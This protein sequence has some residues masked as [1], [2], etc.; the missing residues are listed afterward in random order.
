MNKLHTFLHRR[1]TLIIPFLILIACLIAFNFIQ[2]DHLRGKTGLFTMQTRF[3]VESMQA[4]L[5]EWGKDGVRAYLNL[6]WV[7]FLFPA[8]YAVFLASAITWA[9]AGTQSSAS[10]HASLGLFM[11]PLI[12]GALDWVENLFHLFLL[13]NAG[14]NLPPIP[15]FLAALAASLKWGLLFLSVGL[16]AFFLLRRLF[17][18]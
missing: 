8:A 11:L 12:A 9:D 1:S 5:T 14:Q 15:T 2:G 16:I 7:D 18:R 10:V 13:P 3:T 17:R 4:V 6:M